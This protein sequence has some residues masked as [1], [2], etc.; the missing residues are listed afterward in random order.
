[1]FVTIPLAIAVVFKAALVVII[2]VR[3]TFHK[4]WKLEAGLHF[5]LLGDLIQQCVK[6]TVIGTSII[7]SNDLLDLIGM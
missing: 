7:H 6:S 1:M 3:M 4:H 5:D 2:F